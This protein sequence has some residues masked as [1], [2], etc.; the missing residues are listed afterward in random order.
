M[1]KQFLFLV[2]AY[3]CLNVF[4]QN[5]GIN[6]NTPHASAALD[7]VSTTQGILVPRM[8]QAERNL[9]AS[10]ATGLL[11]YQTDGT[12][13]FYFYNGSAWTSL[14]GGGGT[15]Y[16]AGTGISIAGNVISNTGDNDNNS[17]NEIELPTQTGNSGK[18]LSTNGTNP[19][20][21]AAPTQHKI[22]FA[23]SFTNGA[24]DHLV[25]IFPTVITEGSVVALGGNT[26]SNLNL[27]AARF[28]R[29]NKVF[30]TNKTIKS[31]GYFF[32]AN[33]YQIGAGAIGSGTITGQ[34]NISVMVQKCSS[35]APLT[36]FVSSGGNTCTDVLNTNLAVLTSNT[37]NLT[38]DTWIDLPL[39]PA[40]TTLIAGEYLVI[41][42]IQNT[43]AGNNTAIYPIFEAIV[44]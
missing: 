40:N 16:T 42:V 44:E 14:S 41:K 43:N 23:T 12:T 25:R 36:A 28:Q 4:S 7:V 24:N 1:K 29:S 20:W 31:V 3:L 8:L 37:I 38:A 26:S 13:G 17:S 19:S 6:T 32:P 34:Q 21:V 11:V 27:S 2:S 22:G 15:T 33:N 35:N 9:I 10:P 5:V 39:N 30:S 18:V